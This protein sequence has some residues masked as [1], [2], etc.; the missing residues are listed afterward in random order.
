LRLQPK[1]AA[2][3]H[4]PE[5]AKMPARNM[6]GPTTVP[7]NPSAGKFVTMSPFSGPKGSPFDRDQTGN[8]ST[9]ALNTGIGFGPLPMINVSQGVSPATA[10]QAIKD[11]GYTD[12]YTP[13]ISMPAST[14]AVPV[15]ATLAIL[16]CIG[17]GK[18]T[19]VGGGNTG[20]GVSTVAPYVAQ[21]ILGFGTN[22]APYTAAGSS[23]DAGA[24]PA[25][26]GFGLK[27]VTATGAVADGAAIEAGFTNRTGAAM[28]TT[29]S[30]F[31]SA[32]AASPAVT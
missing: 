17:G 12:D 22:L 15:L 14:A 19:I 4:S 13:G 29:Q 26:T 32:T 8:Q 6:A 21:P 16:T 27:M 25:F 31:G 1:K 10:P 18:S 11:R 28:A 9:G 23:R 2:F 5:D 20:L 30:A 3:S 7:A 24:G